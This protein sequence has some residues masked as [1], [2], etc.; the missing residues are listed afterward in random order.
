LKEEKDDEKAEYKD[1]INMAEYSKEAPELVQ[2]NLEWVGR[3]TCGP[4]TDESD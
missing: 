3:S 2:L 4:S 1:A